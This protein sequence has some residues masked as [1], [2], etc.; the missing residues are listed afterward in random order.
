MQPGTGRWRGL[1]AK[2]GPGVI[3]GAA[4]DD[5]SCIVT[6]TIAGASFGYLTLWTSLFG[7]PLIMAIQSMCA[8]VGMISG[9]GLVGGIRISYPGWIL[10]PVC[11]SLVIA[12]VVTIGADLGG[13]ANVAQMVTGISALIWMA[14]FALLI[15]SL[16]FFLPYRQ[17]EKFLKWLCLVLFA[18]IAGAL[19]A[20]PAWGA[21]AVATLVPRVEWSRECLAVLVAILGAT[22]SPYFLFWQAAQEVEVEYCRGKRTIAQRRGATSADLERSRLD[23]FAGSLVSKLITYFITLTAAATL[24]THGRRHIESAEQA[25]A[26]L[27]PIAGPAASWLFALG[28]IGTGMLA[29][30]ALAGSSAYAVAEAMRWQA[31]LQDKPRFAAEFYAVLLVSMLLGLGLLLTGFNVVQMLFWASVFNGLL[32]PPSIL[33]VVLLARSRKIMGARIAPLWMRGVGWITVAATGAAAIALL[34]SFAR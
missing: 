31:S 9:R 18:Y 8:R 32:A 16:L 30:P 2:C 25:A 28:V 3:S 24:F 13:M 1:L 4:N 33:L 12:N 23:V 11:A 7:L 5:P 22:L 26:A 27:Q 34:A 29:I 6:Y 10:V 15:T 14:G 21:V 17:I 20:K 19:L